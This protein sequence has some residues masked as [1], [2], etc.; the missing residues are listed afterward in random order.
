MVS[1]SII[2]TMLHSTA[3]HSTLHNILHYLAQNTKLFGWLD[4]IQPLRF[5]IPS[6]ETGRFKLHLGSCHFI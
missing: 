2:H 6:K 4:D 1:Y 5:P 3:L